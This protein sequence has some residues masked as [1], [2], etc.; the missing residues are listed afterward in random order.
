M[1][2]KGFRSSSVNLARS[3]ISFFVC[4]LINVSDDPVVSRLFKYFYKSRPLRARYF[5]YWPVAQLLNYLAEWHPI[6]DLTLKHL[7]LKTVALLALTSSDRGQTLHL[8]NIENADI[9]VE[10]ISFVIFDRLKN[11]G[12]VVKPKVVKCI[13]SDIPSLNVADYVSSYMNRTLAIRAHHVAQGLE[14]PTQLF[15]SWATKKSV[16]KQTIGRWLTSVLKMAGINTDQFAAHSYRGAGL[17]AARAKGASIEKI[18]EQ[19]C[20]KNIKTFQSF[21]SAPSEDSSIGQLILDHYKPR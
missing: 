14:K 12:R 9:T 5:T 19:G 21:Y 1:F 8:L 15:L 18:V 2:N 6:P 10:G 7:T 17:S 4:G 16:T 13:S 11:S 20:W 3:A